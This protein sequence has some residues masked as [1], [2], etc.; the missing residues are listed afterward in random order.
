M[1]WLIDAQLPRR[2]SHRLIE[3]GHD[4]V[5]TLDLA[6]GNRTTDNEINR[7]AN[8]SDRIVISK[9]RDF[10]DSHLV[11]G[12]PKRLLWV[13][14]GNISNHE[15]LAMFESQLSQIETAFAGSSCVELTS[16]GL[17]NHQ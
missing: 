14:V 6:D 10:V 13:T 7:I 5:H 17:V 1:S 2:L 8:Q 3:L 4:A 11:T 9:D 15:L 16:A 12:M